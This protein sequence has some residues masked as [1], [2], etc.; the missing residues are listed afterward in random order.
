VLAIREIRAIYNEGA[1]AVAATIRKLYEMIEVEDERVHRLVASANAAHL[2]K[3]EQ[4]TTRIRRLEEELAGKVR[5]V[6]Q[7]NL[8]VKEL[9]K[10]LKEARRQTRQ[11][12][13]R[14][15]A[16][17]IKDSRN[18][19]LPPSTDRR[20]RT[21]SLRQRSGRKP[22]GQV[23]HPGTTLSFV[24]RPDRLILH[25]PADCY[26]CGSS[27]AESEV[28]R[29]ERRQVHDLPPQKMEVT[30]HQAQT[31]VCGRCGAENK[32]EFPVGVK[33]PVQYG[34]GV[35]SVAAYLM[36][37]QLLPYDRCAEAMDDL[38]ACPLSPGTLA[39]LLKKGAG[40]LVGAE[41][42]IREGL[43][44][45]AVLG[46]DETGLRVSQR[47][48]WVHVSSTE[49]LTLL[50]HDRRRGRLAISGIDILPRY[51]GVCVHDGFSSYDQYRQCR[52]A[53]CNA[54][55]LRELNYVIET[56]KPQWAQEM[57]A[58]LLEIKAAVDAKR[59][60][61]RRRLP[62]RQEKEFRR[63]Y[64][65]VV[66][67]AEKL[68]GR[69]ER[70]RGRSKKPKV[71]ESP[72]KAAARKLASRLKDKKD[73]V[74]LFMHDLSVPFDNNQAERDL[75]MLKVKQKVSGCFRTDRGAEEFCRLRSY[76]STMKKQGHR[77]MDTIK[78]LFA[79][80]VLMP[81]LRC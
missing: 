80:K 10:Q 15:L 16:H 38:F 72:I 66:G 29:T 4:L 49:K 71:R 75:R 81:A 59:E 1:Y 3:I 26:L 42:L 55:L 22:G 44:E 52:H 17:L 77:V 12:Q 76:V 54:H 2:R 20:K 30:E 56:S 46:V 64:D 51:E 61:G 31:K 57:K 39:T 7:L 8:S 62:P 6:H 69:L 24:E 43:R 47:Q 23:G 74:Q 60:G 18:S 63:K 58:L 41:M 50:I 35:R 27:L 45:S 25:A 79:G 19:S 36:G 33:A 78:S 11:A 68:Y 37:Y 5:Q 73:H 67:Q 34:A 9:N 14:H 53:Q 40:E 48:D 70:K 21:R 28:A 32:A 13:E 65:E